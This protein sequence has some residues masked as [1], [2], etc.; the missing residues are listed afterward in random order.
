MD[1]VFPLCGSV[2]LAG[3]CYLTTDR[4]HGLTE[5]VIPAL[6]CDGAPTTKLHRSA[7]SERKAAGTW[8][9]E[10]QNKV[11]HE[12]AADMTSTEFKSAYLFFR[13]ELVFFFSGHFPQICLSHECSGRLSESGAITPCVSFT[14][15]ELFKLPICVFI[16][17][18]VNYDWALFNKC[19]RS[20]VAAH[21]ASTAE[22]GAHDFDTS[23][24][25]SRWNICAAVP[26]GWWHSFGN[27]DKVLG[28]SES[29]KPSSHSDRRCERRSQGIAS[30]LSPWPPACPPPGTPRLR[31]T[32]VKHFSTSA[33][34][35]SFE[36]N[37][38]PQATNTRHRGGGQMEVVVKYWKSKRNSFPCF[39]PGLNRS[40]I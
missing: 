33:W 22:D 13:H 5:N 11:R 27:V 19:W 29:G 24:Q 7:G 18:N 36:H 10:K 9:R 30:L 26:E 21:P 39:K 17:L 4:E 3:W 31:E 12:C 8:G 16:S 20:L 37:P 1:R 23:H 15:C 38:A 25:C 40:C 6:F 32:A 2:R 34:F 14:Y 28:F 35:L